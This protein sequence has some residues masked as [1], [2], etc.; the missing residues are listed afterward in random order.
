MKKAFFINGGAGRVLCSIPALESYKQNEDEDVV[1]VAEAWQELFLASPILR[2]NVY[3]VMHKDLFIDKLKDREIISPEPYRLNAYFN[4][5]CN[6]VQAFDILINNHTDIPETKKFNLDINKADQVNGYGLVEKIKESTNK[7]KCVI[8]QPFGS[9]AEFTG[10]FIIDS[11]GRSFDL[12]DI[13]TILEELSKDYAVIVMSTI[14]IPPKNNNILNVAIPQG[15]SLLQWMG[16]IKSSDY[17]LGCDSMGQHYAHALNKPATVVIGST[18][19]ENIT[20]PD[21]KDFTIIDNGMDKRRYA[22]MRITNDETVE[23]NNENLMTMDS[24]QVKRI[25]KSVTDKLGKPKNNQKETGVNS[26]A[27]H[28]HGP[29]CQ[30]GTPAIKSPPFSKKKK[31]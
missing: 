16:I 31:S 2:D 9:G 23:R 28:I 15:V 30:H 1:I 10:E 27:A 21:N 24:S 7:E 5:K 11:S 19:P 13:Y 26:S 3:S 8:F 25:I 22:P 29:H 20:Y 12:K 4:Q 18:F 17:F 6:L 14:D